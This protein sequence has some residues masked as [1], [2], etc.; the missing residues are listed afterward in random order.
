MACWISRFVFGVYWNLSVLCEEK[1]GKVKLFRCLLPHSK[2]LNIVKLT[3]F[4]LL[5]LYVRIIWL[6][7]KKFCYKEIVIINLVNCYKNLLFF[8][9]H[10]INAL[11]M[12]I[13]LLETHSRN[14]HNF[15]RNFV[16]L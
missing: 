3:S 2:C 10:L 12:T 6:N 1:D 8:I 14:V 13:G 16:S 4:L 7:F 15:A 9:T 5:S 11:A